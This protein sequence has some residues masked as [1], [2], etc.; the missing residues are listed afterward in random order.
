MLYSL[1]LLDC[2]VASCRHFSS[3]RTSNSSSGL[4]YRRSASRSRDD[5]NQ[6]VIG[7]E[8]ETLT[9]ERKRKRTSS[10]SGTA[11]D[12]GRQGLDVQQSASNVERNE[13]VNESQTVDSSGTEPSTLRRKES[14]SKTRNSE[15]QLRNRSD[16]EAANSTSRAS[17]D[18]DIEGKAET[19]LQLK[20][21]VAR[22][23]NLKA[24]N[25]TTDG[26]SVNTSR[27]YSEPLEKQSRGSLRDVDSDTTTSQNRTAVKDDDDGKYNYDDAEQDDGTEWKTK[28]EN[29]RGNLARQLDNVNITKNDSTADRKRRDRIRTEVNA[30]SDDSAS[31]TNETLLDVSEKNT[32]ASEVAG[33]SSSI[34]VDGS[35]DLTKP[36][37]S[38]SVRETELLYTRAP[39][40]NKTVDRAVHKK[41]RNVATTLEDEERGNDQDASI[42]D[43][44]KTHDLGETGAE[45]TEKKPRV[46]KDNEPRS[47]DEARMNTENTREEISIDDEQ[48]RRL[49]FKVSMCTV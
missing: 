19:D 36:K 37:E 49:Q 44:G 39:D 41:S 5:E 26:N 20:R 47:N 10:E 3:S 34:S 38:E 4:S 28:R 25:G 6:Q 33:N 30:T 14:M 13:T 45:V 12:S 40:S 1:T 42:G 22:T 23:L 17:D 7:S 43:T 46:V 18:T 31:H 16:S 9:T 35:K 2:C 27:V 8:K 24:D 11:A 48:Q 29:G 15:L 32:S 21:P